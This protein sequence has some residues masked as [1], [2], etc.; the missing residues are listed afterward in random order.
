MGWDSLIGRTVGQ[1]ETFHRKLPVVSFIIL[2]LIGLEDLLENLI[3]SV[4]V[5][6]HIGLG[7]LCLLPRSSSCSSSH[8]ILHQHSAG[9]KMQDVSRIC[10]KLA[11]LDIALTSV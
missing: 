5:H 2:L 6:G 3:V 7:R 9:D 11:I 4:L 8:V 10:D 1:D